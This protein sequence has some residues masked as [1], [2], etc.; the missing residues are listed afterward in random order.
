VAPGQDPPVSR[1]AAIAVAAPFLVTA[2]I[3]LSVIAGWVAG[4]D[5][6]WPL[7]DLN[8]AEAAVVRDHAE[9]VR[10]IRL[11]QDPNR[12]WPVRAEFN[13]GHA[14]TMTP[15]EAAVHIKRLELVELLVREGARVAGANRTSLVARAVES[16]SRDIAEYLRALPGE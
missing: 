7:P 15:L 1:A 11:G 9:V 16:G 5:P 8:V 6:L 3:A 10:L 4:T 14:A 12:S 13:E 2:A